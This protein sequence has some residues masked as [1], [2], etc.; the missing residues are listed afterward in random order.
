MARRS[1]K[2]VELFIAA[3][4]GIIYLIG[5]MFTSPEEKD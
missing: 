1:G 3:L 2:G 4:I 5:K